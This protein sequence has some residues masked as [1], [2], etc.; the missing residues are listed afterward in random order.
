MW[1]F[2]VK[3]ME[4]KSMDWI[5]LANDVVGPLADS[6]GSGKEPDAAQGCRSVTALCRHRRRCK[7]IIKVG[8]KLNRTRADSYG[9]VAR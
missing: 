2:D 1:K 9:P 8:L 3:E 7:Y 5:Q 4:W 6:C